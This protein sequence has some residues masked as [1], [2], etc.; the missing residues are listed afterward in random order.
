MGKKRLAGIGL[1]TLRHPITHDVSMG[2]EYLPSHF[3]LFMWPFFISCTRWQ[4]I[5]GAS[6]LSKYRFHLWK[7]LPSWFFK[8]KTNT[9]SILLKK[10]F[11]LIST[12]HLSI[13]NLNLCIGFNLAILR[14]PKPPSP[15]RSWLFNL[16]C[17]MASV[18]KNMTPLRRVRSSFLP[19]L[20]NVA[21]LAQLRP[22]LEILTAKIQKKKTSQRLV[23]KF[24]SNHHNL[25]GLDFS[26]YKKNTWPFYGYL[27]HQ[28]KSNSIV[29]FPKIW[30][31]TQKKSESTSNKKTCFW[32]QFHP[33]ETCWSKSQNAHAHLFCA[34]KPESSVCDGGCC[35]W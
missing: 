29:F 9:A 31:P 10:I 33:F 18:S 21:G 7:S 12:S 15:K 17:A 25:D 1:S 35:P 20:G 22:E 3:P 4:S 19:R 27:S 8:Q 14:P 16:A 24:P 2:Q 13:T 28:S 32:I 6:A 26:R 30:T 23:S 34:P 11:G 5:H